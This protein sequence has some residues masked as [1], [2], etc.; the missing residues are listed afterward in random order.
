MPSAALYSLRVRDVYAALDSAPG[1]LSPAEAETRRLLYG[2][3]MIPPPPPLPFWRRIGA[4]LVHPMAL[5]LWAAGAVALVAGQRALPLVIWAV[6]LLNAAFSYWQEYRAEQA[7]AALSHLLPRYARV[8][9][10]GQETHIDSSAIV[11]GDVLMLAQGDNIP[12]D[13]RLVECFGL[14]TNQSTL[15]GEAMA[16]AKTADASLRPELSELERPNLVFAG[17]SVIAGTGRAV[18]FA[19]GGMTQFGR[20]ASLTQAVEEEPSPLERELERFTRILTYIAVSLGA[21][22]FSV[23]MLDVGLPQIQALVLGVGIVVATIPEGLRPTVTLSLAIAVQRLARRG[24]LVKKLAMMETLGKISVICT[25]KSGTLT[26][27]Q[28]AVREVWVSGQRLSVSGAGYEPT[29]TFHPAPAEADVASDLSLMLTAALLCNNA[30]LLPPNEDRPRWAALGDQTE[31]ALK[32]MALKGGLNEAATHREYPR[33]HE[34]PFD[35]SRKRMSTIHRNARGEFAF[36]KGAPKEVLAYCTQLQIDG[37]V[38]PLL[39]ED[40][41]A[42]AAAIDDYARR[43]LRVLAMATRELPPREGSYTPEK[44]ERELTFLGLAAMMDPPREEVMQAMATCRSAGIRVVMV[45]GDYGLTAESV[46]RRVGMLGDRPPRIL[47]GGDLDAMTDFELESVL[48]EDVIFARVAPEHKLRVVSAFQNR[49]DIVAMSGDGVNDGPALRKADVG[50][51]MGVTGTDVAREAA[52]IVLTD[53]NF[54]AIIN[55]VE[56]GR[57]VYD[58]IRNFITY[59]LASNIPEVLPFALA[60]LLNIPLALTVA[61]ILAID[62]G[63]DLLPGLALGAEAPEPAIMERPPR[64]RS[65]PLIDRRL[66]ERSLWLGGIE[67]L[68]CYAGFFAVYYTAGYTDL[69]DLPRRDWIPFEARLATPAGQVY[70]LATTVFFAGVVA[71]QIGNV[72]TC[73][74]ET[75]GVHRLG[76]LSNRLLLG[77]IAVEVLLAVALIYL[78]PLARLFEHLPLPADYWIGLGAFGP[79]LYVLDRIRKS[80]VSRHSSRPVRK[81]GSAA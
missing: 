73:R 26:L 43:A 32:A 60:S 36:V 9:R 71:A 69:L 74:K 54:A 38:R 48:S 50:V 1:G 20:I 10:G 65:Q 61:Q 63:T 80:L 68:L 78:P 19:T 46:A 70:A 42:I 77:A 81:E 2:D 75:A 52:D 79:I 35:A 23:G 59:I 11:P 57:G 28:M 18:V 62:L 45:T 39:Q 31:A 64:A 22:V 56:E 72:L 58:N 44:V 37:Q 66:I 5:L 33:V 41:V 67:V 49:G 25:D 12:A 7:V 8:M 4:H 13:A 51:S 17:T 29:G 6:V 16:S 21:V 15:T 27:N 55:A 30:R 24:V 3:N 53:D 14:R 34:L 76:W 47:T 40:R